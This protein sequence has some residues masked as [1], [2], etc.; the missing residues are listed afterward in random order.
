MKASDVYYVNED[1]KAAKMAS[2]KGGAREVA[3]DLKRKQLAS[4]DQKHRRMKE[5][6]DARLNQMEKIR[7]EDEAEKHRRMQKKTELRKIM[8]EDF[9]NKQK[10]RDRHS[11]LQA[12]TSDFGDNNVLSYVYTTKEHKSYQLR[13]KNE[14]LIGMMKD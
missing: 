2:L 7:A 14:K 10:F 11:Q 13:A 4:L 8:D 1:K 9:A 3:E 6:A 12:R 5:D